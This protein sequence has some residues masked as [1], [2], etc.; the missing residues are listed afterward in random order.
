M[1]PSGAGF[2]ASPPLNVVPLRP[3]GPKETLADDLALSAAVSR[4]RG[5][6]A[7]A[8]ALT[9]ASGAVRDGVMSQELGR[10]LRARLL[11][12][13]VST[14]DDELVQRAIATLTRE[15]P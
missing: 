6:I 13:R 1:F 5:E 2:A 12:A 14:A 8:D 4:S 10:E 3:A 9:R 7:W 15:P 11:V